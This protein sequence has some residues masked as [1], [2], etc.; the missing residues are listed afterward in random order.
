MTLTFQ[1]TLAKQLDAV[2]CAETLVGSVAQTEITTQHTLHAGMYAR[3]MKLPAGNVLVGALVQVETIVIFDGDA[4]VF[5]GDSTI[6]LT[7]HHV[8]AASAFRKQIYTAHT[9][10]HITAIHAT[11][12]KTVAEAEAEATEEHHRLASRRAGNMNISNE[13]GDHACLT[14]Q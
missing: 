9:D 8:I 14:Q 3:T 5:V 7:G 2:I 11:T 13:S 10:C 1:A 6:R 4:D 12:A